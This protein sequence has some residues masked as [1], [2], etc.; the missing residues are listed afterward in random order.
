MSKLNFCAEATHILF[1]N[2]GMKILAECLDDKEVFSYLAAIHISFKEH[3]KDRISISVDEG[4]DK[5][6]NWTLAPQHIYFA[7]QFKPGKFM[8]WSHILNHS[9]IAE[10]DMVMGEWKPNANA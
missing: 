9:W 8:R 7:L 1:R 5:M 3:T 10:H 4:S 6:Y 2:L